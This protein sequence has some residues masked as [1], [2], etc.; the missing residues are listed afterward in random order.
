MNDK[1][2]GQLSALWLLAAVAFHGFVLSHGVGAYDMPR[3]G[4]FPSNL[5]EPFA[6]LV[7]LGSIAFLV[8]I[9]AVIIH[10]RLS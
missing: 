7:F 5:L 9:P 10:S 6:A 4:G 8:V 2:I 1:S 3:P